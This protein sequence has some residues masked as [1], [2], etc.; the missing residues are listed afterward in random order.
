MSNELFEIDPQLS[1]R[2]R[3]MRGHKIEVVKFDAGWMAYCDGDDLIDGCPGDWGDEE[4]AATE[5]EAI[6][7]LMERADGKIKPF[8]PRIYQQ[9]KS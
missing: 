8:D 2:L 6:A 3:W 9:S 1:P 4:F 5:D 7:M